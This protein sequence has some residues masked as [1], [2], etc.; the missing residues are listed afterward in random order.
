[1][2]ELGTSVV[3]FEWWRLPCT[4]VDNTLLELLLRGLEVGTRIHFLFSAYGGSAD[5]R[6]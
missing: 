1:M 5:A 4:T 6:V 2:R 3:S